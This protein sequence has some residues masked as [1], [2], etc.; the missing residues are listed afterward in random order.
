[1]KRHLATM[2]SAAVLLGG[3]AI[4]AQAA[5]QFP[6][7]GTVTDATG[8][9]DGLAGP[10][11]QLFGFIAVTDPG[12]GVAGADNVDLIDIQLSA[13]LSTVP[14]FCF[15]TSTLLGAPETPCSFAV[16]D[17]APSSVA[18]TNIFDTT[19]LV[20]A[21]NIPTSG[22]LNVNALSTAFGPN[23]VVISFDFGAG[24]FTAD[25]DIAGNMVLL[26]TASGTFSVVPVPAAAWLF[27]SALLGLFGL[28]RR[29]SG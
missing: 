11:S 8:I 1:M 21:G 17:P 14:G 24:T 12:S 29:A 28:R 6:V 25:G 3:F 4:N 18:I 16:T 26:G 5:H 19:S 20:L 23:N 10:G 7:A 9:L 2:L 15:N 22:V 13:D 27:G